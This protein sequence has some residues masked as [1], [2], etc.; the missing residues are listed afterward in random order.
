MPLDLGYIGI[1]QANKKMLTLEELGIDRP[2]EQKY[3]RVPFGK[4]M[5]KHFQFGEGWKN[6]NHGS[7]SVSQS[8]YF[9]CPALLSTSCIALNPNHPNT[10]RF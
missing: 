10:S 4:E 1:K 9:L 8:C 7:N 6:M 2:Q 3:E 5:R